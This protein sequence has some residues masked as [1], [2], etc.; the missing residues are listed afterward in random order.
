MNIQTFCIEKTLSSKF[1][2]IFFKSDYLNHC[3]TPICGYRKEIFIPYLVITKSHTFK[4]LSK[5]L[6]VSFIEANFTS[7]DFNFTS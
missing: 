6:F 4:V 1:Q 5:I 2:F 7:I 3:D